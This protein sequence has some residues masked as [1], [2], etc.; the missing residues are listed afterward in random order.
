[1]SLKALPFVE[2]DPGVSFK[3][4]RDGGSCN[5]LRLEK[6]TAEHCTGYYSCKIIKNGEPLFSVHHSLKPIGKLAHTDT[7]M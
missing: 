7:V 6:V 5:E 2:Q 1:M 3:W 4:S